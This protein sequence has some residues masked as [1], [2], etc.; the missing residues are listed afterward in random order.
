M[1]NK[2]A[3]VHDKVLGN[4]SLAALDMTPTAEQTVIM[5]Q[6]TEGVTVKKSIA[7]PVIMTVLVVSVYMAVAISANLFQWGVIVI[8]TTFVIAV[9]AVFARWSTERLILRNARRSVILENFANESGL[10]YSLLVEKPELVGVIF[11][12]GDSSKIRDRFCSDDDTFEVGNYEYTVRHG[13]S[14]TTYVYGYLRIKLERK[15]AHMFL[16]SIGNNMNIFG[17]S[18]SNIPIAMT[19]DQILSLEGDFDKY[20]TLYAPAEYEQDAL[21]VFT[22]DLMALLI[23]TVA[24]YDAEVIDDQLF[25]YGSEFNLLDKLVWEKITKIVATVGEKTIDRTDYYADERVGNRRLNVVAEPGKRL[26]RGISWQTKLA[27][28]FTLIYFIIEILIRQ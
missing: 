1:I 13:K 15:V 14:R 26:R 2:K 23:D 28:G 10:S 18:F 24:D 3:A 25:I 6:S 4:L 16:D 27:V 11:Q 21:Y 20:F 22:P 19:S 17:N 8:C 12:L 5:K 7:L 9:G